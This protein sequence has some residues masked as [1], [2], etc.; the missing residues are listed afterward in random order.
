MNIQEIRDKIEKFEELE[1]KF[2]IQK[3]NYER[4]CSDLKL[5][6]EEYESLEKSLETLEKVSEFMRK[7]SI[8]L[9]EGT[10]T[11]V[12]DIVNEALREIIT[13]QDLKFKMKFEE[14]R[15]VNNLE[16]VIEENGIDMPILTSC[17]VGVMNV[18]STILRIVFVE[19]Q[20]QA[21]S[22]IVLDEPGSHI[23]KQNQ[24]NFGKFLSVLSERLGHQLII[25]THTKD[26]ADQCQNI[27]TIQ[28]DKSG[29]SK[30]IQV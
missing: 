6:Q 29:K 20:N 30:A 26:I 2:L 13:D 9:R 23:S 10:K 5:N 3:G 12:E 18:V 7:I 8:F 16:F 21:K 22:L 4:V 1:D 14:K 27:I 15:N 17:G 24:A 25:V 11:K 19:L 28:K